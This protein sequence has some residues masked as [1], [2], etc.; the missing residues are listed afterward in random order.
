MD[1]R[2]DVRNSGS[3]V[4][5]YI[6]LGSAIGGAV[7]YL[8]MTESGR[9]IRYNIMHPDELANNLEGAGSLVERKARVVTEQVHGILDRAKRSIEEGQYAY[10][11][12]GQQFRS[13]VRQVESKN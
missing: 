3:N 12:A 9:K 7:G 1:N 2:I 6:V 5:P 13:R 10:R 11:E 4:W 8:F